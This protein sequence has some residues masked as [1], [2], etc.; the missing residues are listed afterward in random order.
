MTSRSTIAV[1]ALALGLAVC[2]SAD[3]AID[4]KRVTQAANPAIVRLDGCTASLI[5]SQRILTAAHCA[6]TMLP[7]VSRVTIAGRRYRVM[8]VA[9]DPQYRYVQHNVLST[10]PYAPPYDVA[11]AE[12]DRPVTGVAP[13]PLDTTPPAPG[14]LARAIGYG[15]DVDHPE[16][17]FGTLREATIIVRSDARCRQALAH[18]SLPQSRL[19]LRGEM[20]C[21]QDPGGH[22]PYRSAC[23]GDSGSP[24]LVGEHGRTE[25]AGVDS[26]SVACGTR[27]NDPEVYMTIPSTLAFITAASPP[28]EPEPA[29]PPTITGTPTVGST[30]TCVPPAWVG[31]PPAHVH[32][33]WTTPRSGAGG[34]TYVVRA[35]DAGGE[36]SCRVEASIDGGGTLYF[37]SAPVAA[38][39]AGY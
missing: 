13:L 8:S 19:Y 35:Q 3:A 31:S 18:A 16:A 4:G 11:I 9:R 23:N 26:W 10:I 15:V 5:S 25:I 20:L 33:D 14:Q 39:L 22:P 2:A 34:A 37:A 32:F 24:L 38:R 28:W 1:L 12:L 36:I 6:E 27:D 30:L 7:S 21:G 17:S 29:G